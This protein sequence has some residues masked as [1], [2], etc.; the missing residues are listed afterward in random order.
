MTK[1]TYLG[2]LCGL[3]AGCGGGGGTGLEGEPDAGT[4]GTGGGGGGINYPSDAEIAL[5]RERL[6]TAMVAAERGRAALELLG[7]F[8]VYTC[9]EARSAWIAELAA[10]VE[11]QY[12]CVTATPATR[13]ET[14]DAVVLTFDGAGCTVRGHTV[15]GSAEFLFTSGDDRFEVFA[16]LRALQVDGFAL[17]TKVGYGVCGDETR[18]WAES[19]GGVPDNDTHQYALDAQLR[20]REGMPIFG[21]TTS[22]VDGDGSVTGPA[23]TDTLVVTA[24]EYSHGEKFPRTGQVELTTAGGH[25]YRATFKEVFWD[26][27]EAEV[28]IDGKTP[29]RIP[30]LR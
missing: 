23:G 15:S 3:L 24:L 9:G 5:A 1:R 20:Q 13:G 28:Q 12:G 29:V 19:A 18:Y 2:L 8:P 25:R 17:Q 27:G 11:A 7:I 21:S 14:A 16:D 10:D 26:F 22:I 4:P 6:S 30:L